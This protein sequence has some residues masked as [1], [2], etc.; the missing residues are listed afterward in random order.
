[1]SNELREL[2]NKKIIK[3]VSRKINPES[4]DKELIDNTTNKVLN[5]YIK[6]LNKKVNRYHKN[7][8]EIVDN[9]DYREKVV[10]FD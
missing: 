4:I 7:E 1:M 5:S 6:Y 2:V 9:I 8:V 3:S 10:L